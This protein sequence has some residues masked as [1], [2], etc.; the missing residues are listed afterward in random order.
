MESRLKEYPL[1]KTTST[2]EQVWIKMK[3]LNH[4]GTENAKTD[5]SYE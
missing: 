5:I 2:L 1:L 3:E 4:G